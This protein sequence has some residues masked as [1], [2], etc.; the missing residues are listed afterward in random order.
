VPSFDRPLE[1]GAAEARTRIVN[2][3][4]ESKGGALGGGLVW[5]R[6]HLGASLD[7]YRSTYG[8]V[9]EDDVT[10]KMNRDRFA[11][12]G[13]ARDVGPLV[14]AVRGQLARTDYDHQELEGTGEV[15]TT[16][17]NKGTDGRL[18]LVHRALDVGGGKL[19]GVLGLQGETA[20][21]EALGDEAF[22]PATRTRSAAVFVFEEWSL[23]DAG[24]LSAGVRVERV[25]VNSDGDAP[26]APELRFG[27]A[28]SRSFSPASVAVGGAWTLVPQWRLTGN[29]AYTERAPTSYELYANG[30]HVA[31]AAFERGDTQ[32]RLEKGAS[33]DA[34]VQWASGENQV[35]LSVFSSRFSNYIALAATGEPD[36][37]DPDGET[38]AIYAFSGVRARL[39]GAELEGRWRV[40]EG[41]N[42]LDVSGQIDAVRG[43]NRTRGEPLPRIAPLRVTLGTDWSQG[44]W[45]ARAEVQHSAR[46]SRVPADDVA[47]PAWTLLNASLSWKAPLGGVDALVFAK[48]TN[49]TN[50]RAFNAASIRT[51]RELSPLPG[52]GLTLGIRS[53]F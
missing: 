46:Q 20:R 16:F 14:S 38:F 21:F 13:E 8:V 25:R 1:G 45:A 5:D 35:K 48:A 34:G 37:V 4:S 40:I 42:T 31:T 6:G 2:S 12:G 19:Q 49:L 24:T 33:V 41:A 36:F 18:E 44:P 39:Y 47:T 3:A 28:Q 10:I 32:Q 17:K 27:P 11:L 53:T 15:G 9:V 7:T 43:D 22:V 29:L 30:V 50:E 52:R 51:V 23:A 26:G